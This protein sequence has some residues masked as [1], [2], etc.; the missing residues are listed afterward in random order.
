MT[1]PFEI[2]GT[3]GQETSTKD[4]RKVKKAT[5]SIPDKH[6]KETT[7]SR[8]SELENGEASDTSI[9]EVTEKNFYDKVIKSDK[10]VLIKFYTAV[11]TSF[12]RI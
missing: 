6:P 8:V 5:F 11:P 2:K 7:Q 3:V 9:L 12:T 1:D 10:D 4:A